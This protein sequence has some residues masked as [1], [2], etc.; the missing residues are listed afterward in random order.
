VPE[1]RTY[2]EH[3]PGFEDSVRRWVLKGQQDKLQGKRPRMKEFEL[4]GGSYQDTQAGDLFNNF[5][6]DEMDSGD[7][8]YGGEDEGQNM[9]DQMEEEVQIIEREYR[10]K[11]EICSFYASVEMMDNDH[12]Y[13]SYS[14]TVNLEVPEH[15]LNIEQQGQQKT[16]YD[17]NSPEWKQLEK[18][19]K[20]IEQWAKNE[21]I[22]SI[23]DVEVN[24]GEVRIDIYDGGRNNDPDSLR[25]FLEVDLTDIDK[26]KNELTASLYHLFIELGLAR[27]NKVHYISNNWEDHPH[28][29]QNFKWEGEEPEVMISLKNPIVFP[30]G[31][32]SSAGYQH[33]YSYWQEQFKQSI[34]KE[35]SAWAD[36]VFA[37]QPGLFHEPEFQMK[38]PF[39][40]EFK[41]KPEIEL[42]R[43]LRGLNSPSGIATNP[44]G[45]RM[46][47]TINF[48]P[49]AKD[50]DV[51]DAINFVKFLDKNYQKF[52]SVINNI[53]NK[54]VGRWSK[55]QPAT[56]TIQ[57][58]PEPVSP[59]NE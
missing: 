17:F 7:A 11:F 18:N 51:I 3:F 55:P 13:V 38:R 9:A 46:D 32:V 15:L 56:P 42:T 5:F 29:F 8:D 23:N 21:S 4:M 10:D 43:D 40:G 41:I 28:Q 2:G 19:K 16:N 36:K 27:E 37:S 53:H 26:R 58:Q 49:V 1:D 31:L 22:Y 12:P 52:V 14:G 35:L 39:S 47:M 57:P 24:G 44:Q 50:E 45:L 59:N 33:E 20:A 54:W 30:Q 34:M 25:S 6:G 48:E